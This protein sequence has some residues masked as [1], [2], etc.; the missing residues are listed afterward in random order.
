MRVYRPD[1]NICQP[2]PAADVSVLDLLTEKTKENFH[3]NSE[4]ETLEGKALCGAT[5]DWAGFVLNA[6]RSVNILANHHCS[7]SRL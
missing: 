1:E 7:T 6:C 5:E 2:R 4:T 3:P